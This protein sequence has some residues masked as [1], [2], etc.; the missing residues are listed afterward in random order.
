MGFVIKD[1]CILKKNLRVFVFV[2]IGVMVLGVLFVLSAR[3][4]NVA[5][6][7]EEMQDEPL[8][9]EFVLVG[10]VW[11]VLILPLA[12]LSIVV[13]C[14]KQDT[15]A[16]F[17]K[18]RRSLP[19]SCV[20]VVGARYITTIL[21]AAIGLT[22]SLFAGFMVSLASDFYSYPVI[23]Q[24]AVGMCSVIF[25][26]NMAIFPFYYYFEDKKPDTILVMPLLAVYFCCMYYMIFG[27]G[28]ENDTF[29]WRIMEKVSQWLTKYTFLLTILAV[30]GGGISFATSYLIEK[31][32]GG[33]K[34]ERAVL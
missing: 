3:Y 25:L 17:L 1:M 5:D 26:Y 24:F 27:D 18:V 30:A 33:K 15:A 32:K 23:C 7:L 4:G 8:A 9:Q 34:N 12:F 31:K 2:T 22:G 10:A 21:L 13:E 16:G 11:M 29:L 6:M 20:E 14:F 19:V 28:A